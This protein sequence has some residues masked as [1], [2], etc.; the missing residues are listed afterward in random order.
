MSID[1]PWLRRRKLLTMIFR[2]WVPHN[3][4]CPVSW[5]KP[6]AVPSVLWSHGLLYGFQEREQ[7]LGQS[8]KH[9]NLGLVFCHLIALWAVITSMSFSSVIHVFWD[10]CRL[11][12]FG[13][14]YLMS[15][16]FRQQ[17]KAVKVVI[18]S[19]TWQFKIQTGQVSKQK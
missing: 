1:L 6:T 13:K 2:I 4:S 10:C 17:C 15:A 12:S 16:I 19:Q 18:P 8:I 14:Y 11:N 5:H 7:A 3:Q 9:L